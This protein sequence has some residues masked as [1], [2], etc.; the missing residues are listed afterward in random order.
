MLLWLTALEWVALLTGLVLLAGL[1]LTWR[2]LLQVTADLQAALRRGDQLAAVLE[3]APLPIWVRDRQQQV[4]V[5]NAEARALNPEDDRI[6]RVDRNLSARAVEQG[7]DQT[8]SLSLGS[9]E[10]GRLYAL[11][12]RPLPEGEA[13]LHSARDMSAIEALQAELARHVAAQSEVLEHLRTAIAIFGADRRL[14][15]FNSAYARLW[16]LEPG[17]LADEPSLG[18]VLEAQREQR[19]LPE[20]ADFPAFK[21]EQLALFQ[22]LAQTREDVLHLPDDTTLRVLSTPHPMGGLMVTA[23]DVTDALALERSYNTLIEVQRETLDNLAEGVALFGPDHRLKL[24]NAAFARLWGL[25]SDWLA[26]RPVMSQWFDRLRRLF[27]SEADWQRERDRLFVD[28]GAR[29]VYHARLRRADGRRLDVSLAPLPD[30]SSFLSSQDIT[31]REQTALALAERNEALET[32]DRLKTEFI[33]NMSYELR[34]PLNTIIGFAEIMANGHADGLSPRQMEYA[35]GIL[36]SSQRLLDLISDIL[37]LASVEAGHLQLEPE[38]V[39][40]HALLAGTLA[41]VRARARS[42]QLQLLFD[43]P[44]AIGKAVLDPRRVRQS[45]FHLLSNACK[46]TAPGGQVRLA[47]CEAEDGIAIMVSD[48]G[49]GIAPADQARVFDRFERGVYFGHQSGAGLGL[50]LVRSFVELHGGRVTLESTE[51]AGTTVQ[52]WLPRHAAPLALNVMAR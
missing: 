18:E 17:W 1:L 30:G 11:S 51:G 26:A 21:R 47:A 43:C 41:L 23:E 50:S 31:D 52:C 24:H 48:T 35:N 12:V 22:D 16:R 33:A 3:L 37:D 28:V 2:R 7:R 6:A 25:E 44:P 19:R 4:L 36:E 27:P 20:Y 49:I 39:D 9:A 40:L 14:K 13:V 38:E 46:F 10:A 5:Q 34:T 42:Q 45:L 29:R 32:A 15:Y 8:A